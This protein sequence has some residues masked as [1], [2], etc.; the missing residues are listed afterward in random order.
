MRFRDGDRVRLTTPD[1]YAGLPEG[2]TGT[3]A[4]I[5]GVRGQSPHPD[6]QHLLLF[7]AWDDGREASTWT[8][9][10]EK[11]AHRRS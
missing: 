8:R 1:F 3:V 5:A 10:V 6:P 2:A 9:S 4:L 7:V 11:I